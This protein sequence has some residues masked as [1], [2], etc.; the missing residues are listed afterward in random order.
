[1]TRAGDSGY[2][3]P[4]RNMDPADINNRFTYHKPD[5]KKAALH[6][7]TREY[8]RTVAHSMNEILPFECRE[9]SLMM[10]ALEE[11]MMWANACIARHTADGLRL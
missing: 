3:S 7:E 5:T 8:F 9:K 11:A 2:V 10:S 1:M 4:R 6:E